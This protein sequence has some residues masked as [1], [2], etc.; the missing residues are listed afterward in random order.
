MYEEYTFDNV[1][2]H[3]V[4][5][6]ESHILGT[7]VITFEELCRLNDWDASDIRKEIEY[8]VSEID[9]WAVKSRHIKNIDTDEVYTYQ[10]LK[11]RVLD[12]LTRRCNY[13]DEKM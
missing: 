11:K 6:F 10:E 5:A 7:E 1:V 4:T 2:E 9:G 13:G 8:S 3:V 12:E